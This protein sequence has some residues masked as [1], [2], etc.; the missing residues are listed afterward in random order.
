ME[1]WESHVANPTYLFSDHSPYKWVKIDYGQ[2]DASTTAGNS[3]N[4]IKKQIP[5]AKQFEVEERDEFGPLTMSF[6]S[7]GVRYWYG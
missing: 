1:E 7:K 5:E 2:G 3:V 4:S 6:T